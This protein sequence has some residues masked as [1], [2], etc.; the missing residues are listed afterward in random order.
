M[1]AG[2]YAVIE[3]T[4]VAGAFPNRQGLLRRFELVADSADGGDQLRIRGIV[5]EPG[6]QAADV[7]VNDPVKP[8]TAVSRPGAM[9]GTTVR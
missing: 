2:R 4:P 8:R 9:A 5:T 1:S 3:V 6:P 7:H